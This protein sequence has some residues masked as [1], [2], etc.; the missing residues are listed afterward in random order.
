MVEVVRASVRENGSKYE[1]EEVGS[2][3]A[4]RKDVELELEGGYRV[5]LTYVEGKGYDDV[6]RVEEE[7]R[8][9]LNLVDYRIV[10][11]LGSLGLSCAEAK[12]VAYLLTVGSASVEDIARVIGV[13]VVR[14]CKVV[15]KLLDNGW[16][17]CRGY[18]KTNQVGKPRK[19]YELRIEQVRKLIENKRKELER[20]KAVLDEL[21][22][23]VALDG[24]QRM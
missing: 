15:K 13:S 5:C 1:L 11:A 19:I 4:E 24:V 2:A 14:A 22:T 6:K 20:V 23:L 12:I 21:C 3:L 18:R 16:V 10:K 8:K 9:K 17:R 7:V